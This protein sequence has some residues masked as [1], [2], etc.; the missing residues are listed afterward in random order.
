MCQRPE[1]HLWLH[2]GTRTERP[3]PLELLCD[4]FSS[5]EPPIRTPGQKNP[6]PIHPE[7][8]EINYNQL[9]DRGAPLPPLRYMVL[10]PC[11]LRV[12]V[13]IRVRVRV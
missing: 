8:K 13:R 7:E 11:V 10:P 9:N 4:P 12:R 1:F 5:S 3:V 6:S 2:E